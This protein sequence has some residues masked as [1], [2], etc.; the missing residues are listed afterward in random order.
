MAGEGTVYYEVTCPTAAS[1]NAVI[2]TLRTNVTMTKI[3]TNY[4]FSSECSTSDANVS[5][6]VENPSCQPL[7]S[8]TK[9]GVQEGYYYGNMY[10]NSTAI[11]FYGCNDSLCNDCA[12]T[13]SKFSGALENQSSSCFA[14]P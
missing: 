6:V 5:K 7:F 12:T 13:L 8:D 14:T 9:R 4:I 3:E 2:Q 1:Q 10:C 11:Y